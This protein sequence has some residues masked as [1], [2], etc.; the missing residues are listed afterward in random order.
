MSLKHRLDF[1]ALLI[2][3]QQLTQLLSAS[4][5]GWAGRRIN[6]SYPR[7]L[8]VCLG[9]KAWVSMVKTFFFVE[10][11]HHTLKNRVFGVGAIVYSLV[12][13]LTLLDLCRLFSRS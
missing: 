11:R 6:E 9:N 5:F 12:V 4:L 2:L 1:L 3:G 7:G 13:L 8:R 10:G